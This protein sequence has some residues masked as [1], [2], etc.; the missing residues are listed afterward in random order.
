M[1]CCIEHEHI[2]REKEQSNGRIRYDTDPVVRWVRGDDLDESTQ[3]SS[4][5][6]IDARQAEGASAI[7]SHWTDLNRSRGD[8][9]ECYRCR[10]FDRA[11]THRFS[12][13]EELARLRRLNEKAIAGET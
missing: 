1:E 6:P 9:N 7:G 5:A 13:P 11:L 8:S 2:P 10:A 3:P 4:I 12:T